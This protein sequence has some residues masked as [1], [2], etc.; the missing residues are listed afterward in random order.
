MVKRILIIFVIT[1]V[2]GYASWFV[3]RFIAGKQVANYML[4]CAK[5]IDYDTRFKSATAKDKKL[6]IF[7][8][9]LE[10]VDGRLGFPASL[11]WDMKGIIDA[12]KADAATQ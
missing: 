7:I 5:D 3:L 6:A 8:E 11:V 2:V 12:A 9:Q 10:C 1:A 4:A